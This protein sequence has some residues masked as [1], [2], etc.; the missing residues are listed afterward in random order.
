M[1]PRCA[2][3][4]EDATVWTRRT[5]SGGRTSPL[6]PVCESCLEIQ[7]H[8]AGQQVPAPI[9]TEKGEMIVE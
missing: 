7:D 6:V 4:G 5:D 1:M 9:Q 8:C 3:C 2:R